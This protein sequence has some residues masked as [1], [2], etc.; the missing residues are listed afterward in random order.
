MASANAAF[1]K[2]PRVC[3]RDEK[4]VDKVKFGQIRADRAGP[5]PTFEI[6]SKESLLFPEESVLLNTL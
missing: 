5:L 4:M 1:G 6:F 2:R 3:L